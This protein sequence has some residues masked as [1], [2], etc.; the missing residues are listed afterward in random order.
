MTTT[1]F[2][3]PRD[4]ETSHTSEEPQVLQRDVAPE[5]TEQ[6]EEAWIEKLQRLAGF[7]S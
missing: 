6:E 4:Y 5:V 3:P 7:I 2:Y 1:D